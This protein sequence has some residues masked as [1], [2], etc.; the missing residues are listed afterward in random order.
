MFLFFHFFWWFLIMFRVPLAIGDVHFHGPSMAIAPP[1]RHGIHGFEFIV[2]S[3][4]KPQR[5]WKN[6]AT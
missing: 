6:L 2:V 3:T 5:C 4:P 1:P